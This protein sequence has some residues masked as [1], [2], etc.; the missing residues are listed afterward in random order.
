MNLR[1]GSDANRW[2]ARIAASI[3]VA[4][5]VVGN[6]PDQFKGKT[7]GSRRAHEVAKSPWKGLFAILEPVPG[8]M[9]HL[10]EKYPGSASDAKQRGYP[11]GDDLK[12]YFRGTSGQVMAT[13][14]NNYARYLKAGG[15]PGVWS[16]PNAGNMGSLRGTGFI[17]F[18][19]Q[20]YAPASGGK[21]N[22]N[23]GKNV[24]QSF[25]ALKKMNEDRRRGGKPK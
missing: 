5:G 16:A 12:T 17:D 14:S 9:A 10:I 18:L 13:V 22:I 23:W 8:G 19:H 20:K 6:H 15:K 1:H 25:A 3:P 11:A 2:L 24:R 21:D 7:E 4:E